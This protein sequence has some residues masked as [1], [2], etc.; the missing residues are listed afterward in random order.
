MTGD[1]GAVTFATDDKDVTTISVVGAKK[2]TNNL[3]II[4]NDAATQTSKETDKLISLTTVDAAYIAEMTIQDSVVV[5]NDD[6]D[7]VVV[8]V[9]FKDQYGLAMD[10]TATQ[11]KALMSVE[12][13]DGTDKLAT[14]Y[15]KEYDATNKK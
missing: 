6:A 14:S 11:I 3:T 2:G 15:Y 12:Y 13:T 9:S 1:F 10:V 8:P 5:V 4:V 7:D